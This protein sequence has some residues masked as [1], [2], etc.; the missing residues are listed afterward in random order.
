MSL[1][2]GILSSSGGSAP[3]FLY[4]VDRDN[5][6]IT[7]IP[8]E[9]SGAEMPMITEDYIGSYPLDGTS[10]ADTSP[11]T[12]IKLFV[13]WRITSDGSSNIYFTE[14]NANKIRK[15]NKVTNTST[16]LS[17]SGLNYP[18][19]IA[20]DRL[21]NNLYISN[22]L[23]HNI[24]KYNISTGVSS[25]FAGTGVDGYS[26]DGSSA[27]LAQ[28]N[29]PAGIIVDKE[30]NYLYICDSFNNRVRRINL[31]N[32]IINTFAGGGVSGLGDNGLAVNA[33]LS[34]PQDVSISSSGDIFIADFLNDRIRKVNISNN[35]ITTYAGDGTSGNHMPPI[36]DGGPATSARIFRPYGI[37]F[38]SKNNLYISEHDNHMIRR[39]DSSGIIS[40]F[41]ALF[42]GASFAGYL[43]NADRLG[44]QIA[45]PAGLVVTTW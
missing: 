37:C 4:L 1:W 39:V 18:E 7:R 14:R 40:T 16:T 11:L 44:I 9:E 43:R 6:V 3:E 8:I 17:I 12:N 38:D 28:L 32:N 41:A 33:S 26:G 20:Y 19:G 23:G 24:I 30:S 42:G 35:I 36:G 31:S 2:L 22:R 34:M 27:T 25:V 5:G 13:P 15:I 45:Y 29:A 10:G 21:N